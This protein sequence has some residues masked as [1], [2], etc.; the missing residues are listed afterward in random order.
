M[1]LKKIKLNSIRTKLVISLV[2]ICVIPLIITGVCSYNQSKTILSNKLTLTSTQTLT[3]INNGLMDYFH[4]FS[5]IVSM[6]SKE[7]CYC[8][9]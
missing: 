2:A 3:E 6:T 1:R 5:N 7:P 8:K 9:C 4:G